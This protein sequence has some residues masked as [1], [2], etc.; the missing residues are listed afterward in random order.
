MVGAGPAGLGL[1]CGLLAQGVRVRVVDKAAAPARTSRANF[2][3]ARGSEVL[4]RLGALGD[5][6][7]HCL[8][9]M[10]ITTY[11]HGKPTLRLR[12]GDPGLRTS[13]PPMVISQAKVEAAL[14]DRL[15]DLGGHVE[16]GTPL[17]DIRQDAD[18]VVATLGTGEQAQAGWLAGCDG[19]GS[20][21]GQLA[22]ISFPGVKLS[23]RF[24]LADVRLDWNLDRS[25]TS[26]WVSSVGILGAMPMPDGWWRV[27]AYDPDRSDTKPT[28]PEILDRLQQI[29]PERTGIDVRVIDADWLSMFSVH[30]RLADRYRSGRVLIAGDAAHTHAPFG[31]QGMLTGLGDV[32]NLAW[33]LALVVNGQA[34]SALLDTYQ[35]ERRP[36]ATEVL[37]GTSAV[38]KVNVAEGRVGRLVRDRLLTPLFGLPAVQRWVTYRTSQLW[39]SY[40]RGPLSQRSRPT[41]RPRAG[42]RVPDQACARIDAGLTRLHAELRGHWALLLSAHPDDT[43][44]VLLDTARAHLGDRV[45]VLQSVDPGQADGYLVRPD[46][47]L[48]W[49]GRRRDEL[50]RWLHRALHAGRVR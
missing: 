44:P 50:D 46:G 16:W 23:E 12:F 34:H 35:A 8:R 11:L 48:A 3:H 38:T 21:T 26:V 33:K 4:D 28:E 6:P 14:R 2:L 49:R 17:V 25:G 1:A 42:D 37:R 7:E 27:I 15:I 40:R 31:G 5:L 13:A 41:T 47:H 18:G 43:D 32:E 24:L 10:S 39:V 20:A 22:G 29:L 36:L 9:A 19:A 45:T 30:R